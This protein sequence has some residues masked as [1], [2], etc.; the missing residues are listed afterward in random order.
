MQR[1]AVDTRRPIG[2]GSFGQV[3]QGIQRK[4]NQLVAVK[5]VKFNMFA[6]GIPGLG[7]REIS[8]LGIVTHKH[9]AK[10]SHLIERSDTS[11]DF[12]DG[13]LIYAD[14]SPKGSV[15][16]VME[17]V[18]MDLHRYIK[19]V[20]NN[21]DGA[22]LPE[23]LIQ[24]LGRH[25]FKGLAHLHM[26]RII[27]RDIKPGN[28]LIDSNQC[29][30]IADFGL[31]RI[32]SVPCVPMSFEATTLAYR[33]PDIILGERVYTAAFDMWSAGCVVAE[34]ARAGDTLFRCRSLNLDQQLEE[35]FK[36][37]GTPDEEIWPGVSKLPGW[38]EFEHWEPKK[39]AD[40]FPGLSVNGMDLILA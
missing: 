15:Y 2:H 20:K 31:S 4:N 36:N 28:I 40:L 13:R 38:K 39:A 8:N 30:K 29:L 17:Y 33:A 37:L 25:L 21:N 11:T 35:I 32:H 3:F 26:R 12:K 22:A 1:F 19:V 6:E 14:V 16:I 7:L 24:R 23:P 10:Y 5:Q 9:I 34:M 27:H 18:D